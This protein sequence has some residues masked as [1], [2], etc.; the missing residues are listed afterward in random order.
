MKTRF[1]SLAQA[2]GEMP[3]CIMGNFD[4]VSH[5]TFSDLAFCARH[6]LDLLEEGE[7]TDIKNNRQKAQA[8]LFL[9]KCQ[10]TILH[11]GT[12]K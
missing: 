1:K 7:E 10:W 12:R 5:T 4:P 2:V 9:K 11:N 3:D 6:E 8:E